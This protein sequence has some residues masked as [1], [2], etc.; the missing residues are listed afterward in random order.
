MTLAPRWRKLIGDFETAQG[1]IGLMVLALAMGLF[2]LTTIASA[3]A[4]L[5]REISRNYLATNP[6][7]ALIDVGVV[8]PDVLKAIAAN[9]EIE[10][11]E[12]AAI[13]EAQAQRADGIWQR[14]LLFVSPDLEHSTIGKVLP[15]TGQFPP[16]DGSVALEREALSFLG[17]QLGDKVNLALPGHGP[18]ALPVAGAVHDPSLAPSWQEQTAY[19]YLLPPTLAA[20]GGSPSLDLVKV[21][22]RHATFDQARV[23][24][25]VGALG[26]ALREQGYTIHQVQI[27]PTGLHP[28]QSQMTG[29]LG[30]FLMFAGLALILSAVL[31]AT[32]VSGLLA[33]QIRQIAI[34]KAIG[35]TTRQVAVLYFVGLAI[36]AAAATAIALPLGLWAAA[37]FAEVIAELLNF[38]LASATPPLWLIAMLAVTGILLPLAFVAIPIRRATRATVREALVDQGLTTKAS[39]TDLIQRLLGGLSGV[40][41][42]LL[43]AL[44]NAFRKRGRLLLNLALLGAAGAMFFAALNVEAAWRG[45]LDQAAATRDYDIEIKLTSPVSNLALQHALAEVP[46]I[47]DF[48]PADFASAAAGRTDGLMIVRTYPDGGHGSLSLRPDTQ[49]PARPEFLAGS[50]TTG[51]A[52]INQQAWTLLGRPAIGGDIMLAVAGHTEKFTLGGVIRQILTPASAYVSDAAFADMTGH[53]DD[54]AAFRLVVASR[55]S[56]AIETVATDV[57]A[58]LARN[59]IDLEQIITEATLVAAQAG[60]VKILIVALI[61][62]AVIMAGV[63][64]IGLASSQGSSVTERIREFGIMRTIGASGGA[65]TRNILVEGLMIALLSFPLSL[66]AGLPLGYGVGVLVGTLSFGLALPVTVAWPALGIWLGVL[67]V[68]SLVASYAPARRAARLTIRQTLSHQ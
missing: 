58:A 8:T 37:G 32:M 42:S 44:R 3:Y 4:I 63:G 59:G 5:G 20:L 48:R 46:D 38:D 28:H 6:A 55:D 62:M 11:A 31:T 29:V 33:Q 43:L 51:R 65:L 7:S 23:D 24:A 64:T 40:D 25:V 27:P 66:I 22:V 56:T 57:Q 68:G 34:M 54:T 35:G 1:R 60:H 2:A 52:I 14:T 30:M 45:Q 26:A 50:D 12:A 17:L 18:V 41:R 21:A 9:P 67:I 61:A 36:V 49:I 13:I 19:V 39:R 47:E 10:S 53:H 15:G 16:P